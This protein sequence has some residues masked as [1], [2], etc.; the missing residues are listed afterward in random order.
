[1]KTFL[2]NLLNA[3]LNERDLTQS[4]SPLV[5]SEKHDPAP[6]EPQ[7]IQLSG[8]ERQMRRLWAEA[9][10][11]TAEYV[12][13]G[14]HDDFFLCG[15]SPTSVLQL[16]QI[17]QEEGLR[18]D[19][20]DIF[21]NSRLTELAKRLE[22]QT[23]STPNKAIPPFSLLGSAT[24]CQEIR[25]HAAQLCRVKQKQ[26]LDVLPC[27][28]LQAGLLALT[29]LNAGS[30][31]AK[32]LF[33]IDPSINVES[34]R[35]AW[36]Q[37]VAMNP[38]LRTR[39][40]TLPGH[41]I[42]QVILNEEIQWIFEDSLEMYQRRF[43]AE[44]SAFSLGDPLTRFV[45]IGS[46]TPGPR[47]FVWETHH[48]LYD[49]WSQPL[50]LKDAEHAY[51]QEAGP[52]LS[53]MS[54][55]IQHIQ[56]LDP[57]EVARFWA[58][59][60]QGSVGVGFPVTNKGLCLDKSQD[61]QTITHEVSNLK[62]GQKVF[63]PTTFVRAAWA[64]VQA[65]RTNSSEAIFGV[66]VS[67]RQGALAGIEHLA[68]PTIA[69]VPV[70]VQVDWTGSI[71]Q[72]LESVQCQAAD[73]IP[74]EQTG[75][76]HIRRI[77][78]ETRAACGFQSLLVIQPK[79]KKSGNTDKRPFLS[80][81]QDT[82]NLMDER[83]SGTYALEIECELSSS[84]LRVQI[85]FDS[86]VIPSGDVEE[87]IDE[88][89]HVVRQLASFNDDTQRSNAPIASV[90]TPTKSMSQ[91]SE[92]NAQSSP[93][94]EE[95]V[96]S[97]IEKRARESPQ[98]MAICAW[99]GE[100]TYHQLDELSSRLA[101]HLAG[102]PV[103]GT[104]VTLL[105]EKSLWMPV[106]ALAV[107]KAGGALN[108]LEMKQPEER[109]R[110]IV[111]QTDSP[112][113]LCSI[114]NEELA[115]KLQ[116]KRLLVVGNN[117]DGSKKPPTQLPFVNPASLLYVVFTSGSTG[118]P[119]GVQ[120]THRNMRSAITYQQAALQYNEKSRA[121][122]F[123]SYGFDVAWSN[124]F[125]TL[126]AGGCLCIPSAHERDNE[127]IRCLV[128]YN[129]NLMDSTPSLARTLGKEVIS[130]LATL[131][132]GGEAML[133]SDALLAGER[134]TII[135]AY[136]PS[137]CTPTALI[138]K[139]H[140]DG[141]RIGRGHGSCTWIVDAENP[142][143]LAPVG[144]VG[145]LWLEGPIVGDGYLHDAEKTSMAFIR[146]PPWLL[147]H[148][149]RTGRVYRT[150]DLARYE[151]DGS[152]VYIGRKDHQVKIRGQRVELGEIEITL[153]RILH[154]IGA[155]VVVE[156]VQLTNVSTLT[157]VGFVT[158]PEVEGMMEAEHEVAVK[159]TTDGLADRLAQTLPSYMIPTAFF[160]LPVVPVTTTGKTDR[161]QLRE[162]ARSL[163]L[164]IRANEAGQARKDQ[165]FNSTES[166]IRDVWIAILNLT[167]EETS[168]DADFARLG[169][170]SISAMQ[171]VSRCRM[172]NLQLTVSDIL[173]AGTIR[174][175]ADRCKTP[176]L[177]QE[178]A[179][180][181]GCE[182]PSVP[183]ELSPIQQDFFDLYPD[184]LNHY[185]QSFLLDLGKPVSAPTLRNALR[186]IV[187]RHPMLRARFQK[188]P[189]N[190]SW[191]QRIAEDGLEAFAF[192]IHTVADEAAVLSAAQWRQENLDIR[193]G[194]VFACD[195]FNITSGV[196][197]VLLSAHHLVID[198]VS[199]RILWGDVED[200]IRHGS[201]RAPQTMSFQRWCA[202]QARLGQT[203]S[204]LEVLPYSLPDSQLG[205]WGIP[206]EENT[207]DQCENLNVTVPADVTTL[208]FGISNNS[209]RTEPVDLMLAA[210]IRG[211]ALTFPERSVP[212]VWTEA[213]GREQLDG[214]SMDVSETIGWFTAIFPLVVPITSAHSPSH[215][216]RLV[217]DTRRKI[218]GKGQPFS[219]CR[220]HSESGRQIFGGHSVV[221][222]VFNF[223]GRFQ[224]LERDDGILKESPSPANEE[225]DKCH[226][227]QVSGSA[228]RPALIDLT[229]GVINGELNVSFTVH[230]KMDL[231]RIH[232]WM[233][234]FNKDL[235]GLCRGLSRAPSELTLGD[236]SIPS[237]SYR[238]L[239]AL[240]QKSL[241]QMGAKASSVVDVYT[242]S[243]LQEGML[244]SDM[245]GAA[246]YHS[247]T[248]WR[249]VSSDVSGIETRV[250]P[251]LLEQAW[252][253][254]T[255]RH[256]ILS[257]IFTLHPDGDGF[258]QIVL[259]N[260]VIRV[261]Q[262][263][264]E[265]DD[266]TTA[267]LN[268][269]KPSFAP[270]E[271]RHSFTI[272]QSSTGETICRLD[273]NHIL[274]DAHS[275]SILLD[276][277]ALAYEGCELQT[278]P[279]FSE[280]VQYNS[281]TSKAKALATKVANLEGIQPCKFPISSL[282]SGPAQPVKF[283]EVCH[284]TPAF[285][286]DLPEFCKSTGIMFSSIMH[287][288]WAMVLSYYTG[289][290]DVC[291]GYDVSGRDAPIEGVD[292][293]VGPLANLLISR[294]RLNA[295]AHEI[296][297][298]ASIRAGQ[299]LAFQNVSMADIQHHLG[300]SGRQ[301][302]NTS[303]SIHDTTPKCPPNR[304]VSFQVVK[305]ED[306]HEFDLRLNISL[307]HGHPDYV[308]E[309]QEPHVSHEV[310]EEVYGVLIQAINH[311]LT[312]TENHI[313]GHGESRVS[314]R[315]DSASTLFGQFF[316]RVGGIE[317]PVAEAFW[318]T[319]FTDIRGSHFP[320]I[321]PTA[322][323]DRIYNNVS[324]EMK[325]LCLT[326]HD[327]TPDVILKAAWAL[328]TTRLSN[329]DESLFGTATAGRGAGSI[330]PIR[331]LVNGEKSIG[332]F[333]SQIRQ[334][335][336]ELGPFM[337]MRLEQVA[338]IS[339]ETAL[340]CK[341]QSILVTH[342]GDDFQTA[343]KAI[344]AP[345]SSYELCK[346][347]LI[348]EA[349]VEAQSTQIQTTFDPA[350]VDA[351]GVS[352][353]LHQLEHVL[354][355]L[356]DLEL[357]D[358]LLQTVTVASVDDLNTIWSWNATLPS[359]VSGCVHH[360][361]I[362]RANH[363]PNSVAIDAW[364]GSMTYGQLD[365]VSS[366]LASQL[367]YRGLGSGSIVPLCFEK[368]MW[369]PV[370]ALAVMKAGAA[371]VLIEMSYPEQRIRAII[372]QVF[373][374]STKKVILSSAR[375]HTF[376]E[377]F[378]SNHVLAVSEEL[379]DQGV[380]SIAYEPP[381]VHPSDVLY[382]VFTSGTSGNPKGVIITHQ[383]FCSAIAYQRD[384]LGFDSNSRVFDFASNAFDVA[385]LN[386]IKT[387]SSGGCLCI[388][389]AAERVDDLGGAL[390][391]YKATI[392]DLT[393][394]VA[395]TV[396]PSVLSRLTTLILGGEAVSPSDFNLVEGDTKI[397]VAYGPAEC[398]P[399]SAILDITS[400]TE[401]GIG[402]AAGVCTW[403]VDLENPDA[404]A[405]VGA[406]G[407]LWIEGPIVGQGYLN[408][409]EKSAQA[410]VHD[411]VWLQRGSPD[412]Q[413]SSRSGRLYRTGDVVRYNGDGSLVFLG[414]R[415][416]Q[417]KIRGQRVELGDIES[418]VRRAIGTMSDEYAA[419]MQVAVEYLQLD[420]SLDK[421]L[422]A[423]VS[424]EKDSP[425]LSSDDLNSAVQRLAAQ[426]TEQLAG[427]L[428]N[429]MLP[430]AYIPI[431]TMPIS[432]TG[433]ID[434][435][436]LQQ[437][438]TSFSISDVGRLSG[439]ATKTRAPE[440]KTEILMQGL[441]AKVLQIDQNQVT[442]GDNFFQCGG[443]SIGAMRL[444]ALARY[445]DLTFSVRDV[446]QHPVLFDLCGQCRT[447]LDRTDAC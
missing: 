253:K 38:I 218:P 157:L 113:L 368:S 250:C 159:Q 260:P 330:L 409:V 55:L 22:N 65:S 420:G 290:S 101:G 373:A 263:I 326:G 251:S 70:R 357:R 161:R 437:I 376:C 57:I 381:L 136:G 14:R 331:I 320:A 351:P 215:A 194:P 254:V 187:S 193:E 323:H 287:V 343:S 219:S 319:Q 11:T 209:L 229:L 108:A 10:G 176:P 20:R 207:F 206:L 439:Q 134:T 316:T 40:V 334:H 173:Q 149:G 427:E 171:I 355:Q 190:G 248:V 333:L 359:P 365:F 167:E 200:H 269:E 325:Q 259:D 402:R 403:I 431:Q 23:V 347:S 332:S 9:L 398:T 123:A 169:G 235:E 245:K 124:L 311:L 324:F 72:L 160:S 155:R 236:L 348:F 32:H 298:A 392:V 109:L 37:V 423:F 276:E 68:G 246:S 407:E 76:Q 195:L 44:E 153:E 214:Q 36:D 75:L 232:E 104:L 199:W 125:M 384:Q 318:K 185:N 144:S 80:N 178:L 279:M 415:D 294:V 135:N 285:Q 394:S 107:M 184:G 366:K 382:I 1:M 292:R 282:H 39:M 145:E 363:S 142:S 309:F 297:H 4:N 202:T 313:S 82:S 283:S 150:G 400:S 304:K 317:R 51:Y 201:L 377:R 416:S 273:I 73:M 271:P 256:S 380:I 411:P 404:L 386:L 267:L 16:S 46:D 79:D 97:V 264:P 216:V 59:L 177:R 165:V 61:R 243:A 426:A 413:H 371:S 233:H 139:F 349:R 369:M 19:P 429:Y 338:C 277:L 257:S 345:E 434:R 93:P 62:W 291:F 60:F 69:T 152:L 105:F 274:T 306:V 352:R 268:L 329:S 446:F 88:L 117:S 421:S 58:K 25:Y 81:I 224:Q 296:L 92:W 175:L 238:G 295:S 358:R 262:I 388:P 147:R 328:L 419:D 360:M 28:P 418:H 115:S 396:Q 156:V 410:F 387:L 122:D 436:Q 379:L 435:R 18:L 102:I 3:A 389:S 31:V 444:V 52:R 47:Y 132:L 121:F 213:H 222:L 374:D 299:D 278:A 315:V 116:P 314:Q 227:T 255:K 143:R 35:A 239:D 133:P 106:A 151:S 231:D 284:T 128:K 336:L 210:L 272:S 361:I 174:K 49:G 179:D 6:A 154:S 114:Q 168:L 342:P 249:C 354:H 146:D 399:T 258:I 181:L 226:L 408:N 191:R 372:D 293:L 412:G 33:E 15:G 344:A 27:T 228:Q 77:N 180:I 301:L 240:F 353:L 370:A 391:K 428:P 393:P 138:S 217:K 385:W 445:E 162:K 45:L 141:V 356:V 29:H 442:A 447:G 322:T 96:H 335:V 432:T 182:D 118:T 383:N 196:Q 112:L 247:F 164:A 375:H 422:V 397:K 211:F 85:D 312:R 220:S 34:F 275:E 95:T 305:S 24:D 234:H 54:G 390:E 13:V 42:V 440:T 237:L 90:V 225:S 56:R 204:P 94:V 111:A 131:I 197:M 417:I 64:I 443:D 414:R 78:D 183:S 433:K 362:E 205:F 91:V 300:L 303:L 307:N 189:N 74:F 63:T 424:L 120:I 203:L 126:T 17:A 21:E 405:P 288:A 321:Q 395:R 230:Q 266:P 340:A 30:Y 221:E 41:D 401:G 270:S 223:T 252:Q 43:L 438:G 241:P 98:A 261:S 26:V 84:G 281:K 100:I 208:L 2:K 166:I 130:R 430:S 86:N 172:H 289:M 364:D 127:L 188:D 67:G 198:L 50:I 83:D 406:P 137:E 12:G 99:D 280:I 346:P 8:P 53:S 441:W 192:V 163:L 148:V 367:V 158:L 170:D 140:A 337:R 341:L 186:A 350:I 129:I 212:P 378:G 310:A 425:M 265:G 339:G 5:L 110:Q 308:I 119:K 242:C 7:P 66:T 48:A 87:I 327:F 71:S 286:V 89:Q 103:A 302:F 244:L